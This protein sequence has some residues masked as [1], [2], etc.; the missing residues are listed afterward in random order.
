MRPL[1]AVVV[2]LVSPLTAQFD[3][4]KRWESDPSNSSAYIIWQPHSIVWSTVSQRTLV[5]G[6]GIGSTKT[7]LWDGT[8]VTP[9]YTASPAP[10]SGCE[11]VFDPSAQ[12]AFA[13][14]GSLGLGPAGYVSRTAAFDGSD[15]SSLTLPVRPGAR[16]DHAMAYDSVRGVAVLFGGIDDSGPFGDTWEFDGSNWIKRLPTASPSAR[17]G[18]CMAFDAA[19]QRVVMFGGYDGSSTLNDTWEFDGTSW[20]LASVGAQPP[21][22]R[23]AAMAFDSARDRVVVFGGQSAASANDAW[24]FDGSSWSPI[25]TAHSPLPQT[26]AQMAFDPVRQSIVLFASKATSS[27]WPLAEVW[28]LAPIPPTLAQ[29]TP[30]GTG[31]GSPPM[32]LQPV[33]PPIIGSVARLDV[34][35]V[36]TAF[37]GIAMGE[38]NALY[39]PVQLPFELSG[40]GMPGCYLLQSVE[41]FGMP[42]SA[43]SPGTMRFE[44]AIPNQINLLDRHLYVQAYAYAPGANALEIITSNGMDWEIGDQ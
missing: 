29:A 5:V 27:P 21:A 26:S 12:M 18:H 44:Q 36:P 17:S 24:E 20:L 14:G 7:L 3:W 37:A 1:L 19:R 31:C 8:Q 9:I 13:F 32:D 34:L 42:L 40:V 22:R 33:D 6:L 39:F 16:A 25:L 2:L 28:E 38:S 41:W 23:G 30:Y 10:T 11:V 35:N 43:T 15:W 4:F